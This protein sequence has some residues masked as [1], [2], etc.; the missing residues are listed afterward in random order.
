MAERPYTRREMPMRLYSGNDS[1][2]I[3]W[4]SQAEWLRRTTCAAVTPAMPLPMTTTLRMP[5]SKGTSGS[6]AVDHIAFLAKDPD[7][8]WQ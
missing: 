3:T 6:G 1:R 5:S 2:P 7:D 8:R 4:I